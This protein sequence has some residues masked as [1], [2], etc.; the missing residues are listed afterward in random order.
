LPAVNVT[1]DFV[2][3]NFLLHDVVITFVVQGL[4]EWVKEICPQDFLVS[5]TTL[6]I[7]DET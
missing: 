5:R 1:L 4:V 6:E 7:Q 2:L 3:S